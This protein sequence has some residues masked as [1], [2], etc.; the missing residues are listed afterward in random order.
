MVLLSCM[1]KVLILELRPMH[2]LRYVLLPA[3]S[4]QAGSPRKMASGFVGPFV[5]GCRKLEMDPQK[6]KNILDYKFRGMF[7]FP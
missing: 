6:L 3:L 2:I 5:S 1:D 7:K 4:N